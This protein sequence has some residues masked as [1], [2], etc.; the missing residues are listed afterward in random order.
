MME[1]RY[2]ELITIPTFSERF[3][4]LK[5]DGSVCDETFGGGR[6]L[7][8][9]FYQTPEWR[10]ARRRAI[11]RDMGCDLGCSERPI[12]GRIYVHHMNPITKQD[13][14]DRSPNLFDLE[15]LICCSDL[16]HK[17]ITFGDPNI[18]P[19]KYNERRPGDTYLWKPL[20]TEV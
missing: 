18:L 3:E 2:S 15:N 8:Q 1:R 6:W 10:S 11:L 7:N 13:I 19:K 20:T 9:M 4:Y 5:L 12:L 17:A 16:V 14:L